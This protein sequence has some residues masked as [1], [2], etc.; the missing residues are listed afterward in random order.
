VGSIPGQRTFTLAAVDVAKKRE[1]W[2]EGDR[3]YT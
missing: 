1:K 3:E 2:K